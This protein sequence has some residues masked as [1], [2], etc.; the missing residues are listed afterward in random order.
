M[1]MCNML[2]AFFLIWVFPTGAAASTY[3]V[4]HKF[5]GHDGATLPGALV[6]DATGN[7]YGATVAGGSSNS[8]T[9]FKLT[10]NSNGKWTESVIHSFS[11]GADGAFPFGSLIFD[12][13]GS[14]YGT[15]AFGGSGYGTVFKLSPNSNGSWTERVLYAFTRGTDGSNPY[16]GLIFDSSGNLYGTTAFGGS[17]GCSSDGCG[18]VFELSPNSNGEWTES[19]LY[20]FGGTDGEG[21]AASLIFDAVGNLYSTTQFGGTAGAG[22]VFKLT[23]NSKGKWTES[24]LH[25]FSGGMDGGYPGFVTLVF[26]TVGNLYGTTSRGGV[27][28]AQC[29]SFGCGVVF[30]LTPSSDGNWTEHVLHKF[31]AN[32][33]F[34]PAGGLIFDAA[35]NLCG[36]TEFALNGGGTVFKLVPRMNGSWTYRV[37][38]VFKA[39]GAN[40]YAGLVGDKGGDL[41]GTT[42]SGVVFEIMP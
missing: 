4:L 31:K 1:A 9:V 12:G 33:G 13:R 14:L 3:K 2:V 29:G 28:N 40:P 38:H 16:S 32:P 41:F 30:K 10:P 23:P 7:L 21:P 42:S 22:V 15:T 18:V 6:L 5:T 20:T 39:T 35:S 26:D 37:L 11:G 27:T 34:Y 8:G 17:L 25:I 19:V 24:V 36:T